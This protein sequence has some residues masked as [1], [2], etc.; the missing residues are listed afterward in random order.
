MEGSET[1]GRETGWKTVEMMTLAKI[2]QWEWREVDSL[3]K[4]ELTDV[5]K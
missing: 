2:V 4:V 3:K 5:N 1:G